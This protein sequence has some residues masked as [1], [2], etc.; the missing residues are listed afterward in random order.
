M[1]KFGFIMRNIGGYDRLKNTVA[2]IQFPYGSPFI[3]PANG[4]GKPF[5]GFCFWRKV[6]LFIVCSLSP[7]FH[8]PRLSE[9][10]NALV[11]ASETFA[12]ELSNKWQYML[13]VVLT[14]E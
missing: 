9:R 6:Y 4:F 5:A 14:V 10:R 7:K 1:F 3:S 13:L 2:S 11:I 12:L 8:A